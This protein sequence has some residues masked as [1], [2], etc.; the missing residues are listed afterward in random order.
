M[1]RLYRRL[2][3]FGVLV[4]SGCT[5][6][7]ISPS[8]TPSALDPRGPNAAHLASLWWVLLTLGTVIFVLHVVLLTAALLRGRR[9]TNATAPESVSGDVG[10][11]WVIWGGIA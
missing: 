6:V 5:D 2:A 11:R 10:R 1:N 8:N 4:P 3:L 9:A 7:P